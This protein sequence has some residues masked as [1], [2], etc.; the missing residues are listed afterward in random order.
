MTLDDFVKDLY[1]NDKHE[2][3]GSIAN[4]ATITCSA[5]DR[6]NTASPWWG[7]NPLTTGNELSGTWITDHTTTVYPY[8]L[9]GGSTTDGNWTI[10]YPENADRYPEMEDELGIVFIEGDEIKLMTP[11]GKAITIARLDDS[12]DFLPI[13]VIAAKKK[14]LEDSEEEE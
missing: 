11:A 14:L 6:L 1:T 9:Q 5:D 7:I 12:D 3:I 2:S 4:A 8:P 10:T 13:E